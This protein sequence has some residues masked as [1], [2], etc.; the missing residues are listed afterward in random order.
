MINGTIKAIGGLVA[1]ASVFLSPSAV[2]GQAP[3]SKQANV[4][5]PMSDGVHLASD[6]YRP[7]KGERF[8]VV[9]ARTPYLKDSFD[10]FGQALAA[11]GY[12]VVIQDVRGQYGSQDSFA[13]FTAE[14]KD[15]RETL[16]WIA[17]QSWC[18]GKI[19]M[20]GISYLAYCAILEA[21]D[22]HPA[23]KTVV[24]MSG[25]GDT[26]SMTSPGGAMHL[27]L[28]LPWTL[29]NQIH[30]KGSFRDYD[31]D[32]AFRH[33]PVVDIP[34][35]L[36]VESPEWEAMN[37]TSVEE[38][39][40]EA[41]IKEQYDAIEIPILYVTGWYDFLCRTTLDVYEGVHAATDRGGKPPLQRLIIGPWRHD[42]VWTSETHVGEE[43]FGP[44][45]R[46]G[47][48]KVIEL[49]VRWFD[50]WLKDT[51][52]GNAGQPV[53]LFVMGENRWR[54]FSEWPP[55]TVEEV[56]WYFDSE[57]GANSLEGDGQLTRHESDRDGQDRFVFDPM[58][59]VP[60]TGGANMHLFV[61][62]LGI[63]DQRKVENRDD[64]LVYTSEPLQEDLVLAGRLEAILY[65]TTGGKQTD[66]TAKLVEVRADGYARI[67]D[68]GIKRGPDAV[69]GKEIDIM[70][71]ERPY[72]FTVA[73]GATG[74]RIP[75]GHRL[76]VEV[77]SSNFPKYS[78]NPNTG[79]SPEEAT[80]FKKVEQTVLHTPE[81][82]SHV[83]LPVMIR[84]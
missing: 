51:D 15:G 58:D 59:P 53:K 72:R 81:Y 54:T 52:T 23:L 5:I 71:P 82:P 20:W 66:F 9:L 64:V 11:Q 78:R 31:W 70:E 19:G 7:T 34:S 13:P 37:N 63:R 75:K 39:Q 42:Q 12:V 60:T 79:E 57:R 45:A 30:E 77:S 24:F 55:R 8:P 65:A 21:P 1:V 83:V 3:F 38:L 10:W 18:N 33:V 22:S 16:D 40:R 49:T 73:M 47:A 67:I 69:D 14:R 62:N 61:D 74:I 26:E 76:R 6:I 36:G 27:M 44:E 32:R 56:K 2:C 68:D 4:Q 46:M 29:S 41:S 35:F 25:W 43:D 80:E 17:R 50:R 84:K 48:H 28:A